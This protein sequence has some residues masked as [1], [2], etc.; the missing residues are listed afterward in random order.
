[1]KL[2]KNHKSAPRSWVSYNRPDNG[3]Q[4]ERSDMRCYEHEAAGP[5]L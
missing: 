5:R 3:A 1:M 4:Q 2:P